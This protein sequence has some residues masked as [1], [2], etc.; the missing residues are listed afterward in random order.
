MNVRVC[1]CV[2]VYPC[3]CVHVSYSGKF[4]R[5]ISFARIAVTKFFTDTDSH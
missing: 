3:G 5:V 2:C 1:V 4:S